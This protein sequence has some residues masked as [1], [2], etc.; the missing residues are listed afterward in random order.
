MQVLLPKDLGYLMMPHFLTVS[1]G[2]FL[3][4]PVSVPTEV[5]NLVFRGQLKG[6]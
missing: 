2:E 1:L 3:E 5:D 6:K 4:K